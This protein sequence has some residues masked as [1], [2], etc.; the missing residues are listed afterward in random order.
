MC[1]DGNDNIFKYKA[2][3]QNILLILGSEAEGIQPGIL[4]SVDVRMRIPIKASMESLNVSV[5]AGISIFLL[6]N[7]IKS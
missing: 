6:M 1:M 3:S 2:P 4:E 5:S 7:S